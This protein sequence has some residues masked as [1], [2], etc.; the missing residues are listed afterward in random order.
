MSLEE[1]AAMS[2]SEGFRE[3]DGSC[4][5][6]VAEEEGTRDKDGRLFI[7]EKLCKSRFQNRQTA[8]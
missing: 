8:K 2:R 4:P 6:S 7:V 5:P 1:A 3:R